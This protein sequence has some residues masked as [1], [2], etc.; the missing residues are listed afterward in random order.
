MNKKRFILSRARD[1]V[2]IGERL[3]INPRGIHALFYT[4]THTVG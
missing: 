1:F 4:I 3:A 2:A